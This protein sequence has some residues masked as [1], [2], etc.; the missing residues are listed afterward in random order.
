MGSLST[1]GLLGV[2]L[3]G[4][5]LVGLL[6]LSWFWVTL[7]LWIAPALILAFG[8]FPILVGLVLD[9]LRARR[10]RSSR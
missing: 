2:E 4:L 9:E 7:P 1:L 3:V 5:K 6:S 10:A 8:A